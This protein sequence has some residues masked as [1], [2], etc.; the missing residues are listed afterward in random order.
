MPKLTRYL[1]KIFANNSNQVGVF[2]TGVDKETSKNVETL[3]SADYEDGWSSAIITNK[4]YPIWQEMDGVQYGLS[5]QLKYLFQNGI[6]EWIS[7]ETYYTNNYCSY[8]G[9]IYQ[10]LQ[11]DNINHNPALNDG[12]WTVYS[13]VPEDRLHA[14]KGYL[15]Q[16][17]LLT[18]S[19]GLADVKNYAHST[20][21][22]SKFTVVET[23]TITD[24]GIASGFSSSNYVTAPTMTLGN[25]FKLHLPF[26]LSNT[27]SATQIYRMQK[28]S[29]FRFLLTIGNG[30]NVYFNFLDD[31][32]VNSGLLNILDGNEGVAGDSYIA[33]I[34]LK[35]GTL[36]YGYIHN[37]VYTQKGTAVTALNF[38]TAINNFWIGRG[39]SEGYNGSIDLK[40]F[41][42]TVDG[43][44]VFSG[45]KT[46][47]D[48]IK[49]DNYTIVGT[50][51]ISADG[52][53][54]GFASGNYLTKSLSLGF[55]TNGEI[56]IEAKGVF[57]GN[58]TQRLFA[59]LA[60]SVKT[61]IY[62]D[63]TTLKWYF[64]YYGSVNSTNVN[65]ALTMND[66]DKF[67][68]KAIAKA[69]GLYLYIENYTTNLSNSNSQSATITPAPSNIDYTFS[70][71]VDVWAGSIDLNAF[72]VYVD[73]NLVYQPCL[74]IPYTLSKTGSKIVNSVYRDR[75]SDMY[76]QFGY[77]LYYTLSDTNFT[78]PQGEL[79]GLINK[80]KE[81]NPYIVETYKNGSS[82][83]RL[84]SDKWI[85]QGGLVS[86]NSTATFLKSFSDTNYTLT[87]GRL[88]S[89][90]EC[91]GI[92]SRDEN[93]FYVTNGKGFTYQC[94][95]YACGYIS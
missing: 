64:A 53:V 93:G 72:K 71:T 78:I 6:P 73:G 50:P 86:T 23:P 56:V 19:E 82:W 31:N 88:A 26:T 65:V 40:Q 45:N 80:T 24:D 41:S 61:R 39:G 16:G 76:E 66:G 59:D 48:T 21:D 79:Y 22:K 81:A 25:N 33:V 52:I 51:T 13:S 43:V 20:F 42:I 35:N 36:T 58:T 29:A 70:S 74:K 8:G 46:G 7:T 18:D 89:Y 94:C 30:L 75:V 9:Y 38:T 84:Y 87:L 47:I 32:G 85:E 44:E 27:I 10:S 83:Y 57:K 11:D 12:Y 55:S 68:L 4:N 2:G 90:Y 91:E 34:E 49:P 63:T 92:T 14:L 67:Y 77:A 17:E 60:N 62:Y 37:G 5:Y 28:D 95:W 15:D 1:Q 54:S 69:T 3:Q